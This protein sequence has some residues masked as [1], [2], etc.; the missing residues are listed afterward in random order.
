M[1]RRV[2]GSEIKLDLTR[3]EG[4]GKTLLVPFIDGSGC[5]SVN[6][7]FRSYFRATGRRMSREVATLV[8][9]KPDVES[10]AAGEGE[11]TETFS[12]YYSIE[13]RVLD[14]LRAIHDAGL[15]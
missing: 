8:V 10:A 11:C 7:E 3:A 5:E 9:A 13:Q 15:G 12:R 1:T 2:D 4:N 14:H 6:E